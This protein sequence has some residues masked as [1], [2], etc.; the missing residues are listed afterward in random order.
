MGSATVALKGRVLDAFPAATPQLKSNSNELR[1]RSVPTFAAWTPKSAPPAK[2]PQLSPAP[3]AP[4]VITPPPSLGQI[5]GFFL[6]TGRQPPEDNAWTQH[7]DDFCLTP[8]FFEGDDR[9]SGWPGLD[10]DL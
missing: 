8:S 1:E 3:A 6:G 9:L 10:H 5:D 4:V 2:A 7:D